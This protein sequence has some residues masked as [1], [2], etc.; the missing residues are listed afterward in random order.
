MNEDIKYIS[1]KKS[2]HV[3]L[4]KKHHRIFRSKLFLH[5][6]TMQQFLEFFVVKFN[7]E[8]NRLDKLLDELKDEVKEK[9]INKLK[10]I[11]K[12]DLYDAIEKYSPFN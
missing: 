8:D 9:E 5:G 7:N 11:E 2:L 4:D 12:K 6:L 3:N 10:G 1:K